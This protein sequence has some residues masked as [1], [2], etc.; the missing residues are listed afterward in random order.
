LN[1]V[2][3]DYGKNYSIQRYKGLGEMNADQLWETTMNPETRTLIRVTVE[4]TEKAE[5]RISVLMG[6]K[7]DPRRRWIEDNVEFTL[8]EDGS[9]L[10]SQSI[11]EYTSN[12]TV[13]QER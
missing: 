7:V 1:R 8:G 5:K 2:I 9:I 4:D 13:E 3:N 11:D 12:E 10:E 6:N